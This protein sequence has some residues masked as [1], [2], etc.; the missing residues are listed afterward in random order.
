MSATVVAPAAA[1]G[2]RQR[3][4]RG[5]SAEDVDRSFAAWLPDA[6]CAAPGIDWAALP[7]PV[8]VYFLN[9]VGDSPDA[10]PL[11]LAVG[12]VHRSGAM[13]HTTFRVLAQLNALLRRLRRECGLRALPQLADGAFWDH[14]HATYAAAL[15]TDGRSFPPGVANEIRHYNGVTQRQVRA[16]AHELRAGT[17]GTTWQATLD[18]LGLG[19]VAHWQ[20]LLLPA[21]P[22]G[23]F[24]RSTIQS[25]AIAEA[26]AAVL[27]KTEVLLRLHTPLAHLATMRCAAVRDL[28]Q[29]YRAALAEA[30]SLGQCPWRF[31][32][33]AHIP[34]FR[35]NA[36][37]AAAE[38]RY[39]VRTVTLSL[40]IW[41]RV[42]WAEA[43]R[44]RVSQSTCDNIERRVGAYHPDATAYYLE[45]LN[46]PDDFCWFG[47]II[48]Q[49]TLGR[50]TRAS[51]RQGAAALLGEP[52]GINTRPPGL[53]DPALSN[54]V[55]LRNKVR[56]GEM[57]IDI[58]ALYRGI[59]YG[60]ALAIAALTSAPR[61]GELLQ[62]SNRRWDVIET[63]AEQPSTRP[64]RVLVQWVLPK[65]GK[66]DAD[67]RWKL[68]APDLQ[69]LL[70]EIIELL[71]TQH[72]GAVPVIRP[73]GNNKEEFLVPEP[74]L[75]QW[76]ASSNGQTGLLTARDVGVLLRFLFHGVA[77]CTLRGEPFHVGTHLCRHVTAS[78]AKEE[79]LPDEAISYLLTHRRG[80]P[81]SPMQ[82]AVAAATP[83]YTEAGSQS[84][85]LQALDRWHRELA[86]RASEAPIHAPAEKDL[87]ALDP[88]VRG[89]L[90][91]YGLMAATALG[92]C[93]AGLCV[94]D[95]RRQ[96]VGCSY[97]VEDYRML[98]FALR[99]KRVVH[100][101]LALMEAEATAPDVREKRQLLADLDGH[102]HFM[103][104]QAA[105]ATRDLGALPAV[106]RQMLPTQET[107][108]K[109]SSTP[110]ATDDPGLS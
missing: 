21:M 85:A 1:L 64:R 76:G 66:V 69:P 84:L 36:P 35:D 59:L 15:R 8:K 95:S 52:R 97:L 22:P 58:E 68:V 100:A 23:W 82:S 79:G 72:G 102:I 91:R 45:C 71:T 96:C 67:R 14:V 106:L 43:H 83:H 37:A 55:W 57:L 47:H 54:A 92:W 41:D 51:A 29:R 105:L 32:H 110:L 88:K 56:P 3:P 34:R 33:E 20:D 10:A 16:Y 75:F 103:R 48:A 2:A 31:T 61:V 63:P 40:A 49:G 70:R 44:D 107:E 13:A 80:R 73:T 27:E 18:A 42:S 101:D 78:Q 90:E 11:A 28:M 60:A 19:R 46:P 38:I 109:T 50:P 89:A 81:A 93:S 87:A 7:R 77:L 4:T 108:S 65:G 5:L 25:T 12:L 9:T 94:R 17:G 104:V 24:E 74:Y 62:F 86:T 26:N 99:L 30:R 6:V 98:G 53:L 39:D